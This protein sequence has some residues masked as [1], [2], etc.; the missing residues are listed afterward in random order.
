[1]AFTSVAPVAV[2]ASA[3]DFHLVSPASS[4][5]SSISATSISGLRGGEE[6]I[7][8]AFPDGKPTLEGEIGWVAEYSSPPPPPRIDAT[9]SVCAWRVGDLFVVGSR[10]LIVTLLGVS[11]KGGSPS[12]ASE[13]CDA[14]WTIGDVAEAVASPALEGVAPN[15]SAD[16]LL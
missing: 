8:M 12:D 14:S 10:T 3:N 4:F 9:T 15:G 1:M 5:M 11:V 6:A 16:M 7:E 13:V 2:V